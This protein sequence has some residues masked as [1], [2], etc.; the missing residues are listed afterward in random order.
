MDEDYVYS[1]CFF[2]GTRD[3]SF[4]ISSHDYLMQR[5]CISY[6][7]EGK[8]VSW[9]NESYDSLNNTNQTHVSNFYAE[10]ELIQDKKIHDDKD[11][12]FIDSVSEYLMLLLND[13]KEALEKQI[14]NPRISFH[15]VFIVPTKWDFSI[16]ENVLRPIFT[17]AKLISKQDHENKLLFFTQLESVFQLIQSK[18]YR[19][20]HSTIEKFK[21]GSQHIICRISIGQD[22]LSATVDVTQAEYSTVEIADATLVPRLL[23]SVDISMCNDGTKNAMKNYLQHKI[24][25]KENVTPELEDALVLMA[26]SAL[27][28]GV[29]LEIKE[30]REELNLHLS[31]HLRKEHGLTESQIRTINTISVKDVCSSISRKILAD[32]RS[33][34]LNNSR[35]QR[36]LFLL[37]DSSTYFQHKFDDYYSPLLP[38]LIYMLKDNAEFL[39]YKIMTSQSQSYSSIGSSDVFKGATLKMMEMARYSDMH[40]L[41]LVIPGRMLDSSAV[42]ICSKPNVIINIGR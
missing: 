16:R 41:P 19:K 25:P 5:A 37:L 12:F 23:H 20:K 26:G 34:L 30:G 22:T 10:L 31:N 18:E 3:F 24:S 29:G 15:Y 2:N 27:D 39:N 14:G 7:K 17:Q 42:F 4:E 9:G 1:Q 40:V 28:Y 6:N 8:C 11:R 36:T 13:R 21:Q 32:F 38:W 35:K 33:M